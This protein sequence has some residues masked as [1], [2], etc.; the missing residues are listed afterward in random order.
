M[1][2]NDARE[3]PTVNDDSPKVGGQRYCGQFAENLP[4]DDLMLESPGPGPGQTVPDAGCGIGDRE[5]M[6]AGI[7]GLRSG[8]FKAI[9]LFSGQIGLKGMP[10]K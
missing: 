7:P 10:W 8:A 9:M 4:V 5:R 2:I 3:L 1:R 6:A